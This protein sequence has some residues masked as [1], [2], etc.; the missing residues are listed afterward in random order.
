M[1]AGPAQSAQDWEKAAFPN[2]ATH[3]FRQPGHV[4]PYPYLRAR[5]FGS[6]RKGRHIYRLRGAKPAIA[7]GG[8]GGAGRGKKTG[9]P[10]DRAVCAVGV[11]DFEA[12][13]AGRGL[14][15]GGGGGADRTILGG[16]AP[17]GTGALVSDGDL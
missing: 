6:R 14:I 11:G 16:G 13:D 1:F 2:R 17:T 12:F 9:S 15:A 4:V 5:S 10:G 3:P 7:A 8:G